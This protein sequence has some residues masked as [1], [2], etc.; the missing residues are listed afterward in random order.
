MI[1]RLLL[2][3]AAMRRLCQK[4]LSTIEHYRPSGVR[5][6]GAGGR[7][8]LDPQ[9]IPTLLTTSLSD[10]HCSLTLTVTARQAVQ[11][12]ALFASQHP[13]SME[14][15]ANG[16]GRRFFTALIHRMR[17]WSTKT[18]TD[19]VKACVQVVGLERCDSVIQLKV[20]LLEASHSP[21]TL[22]EV[23]WLIFHD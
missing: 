13:S 8:H 14:K 12:V 23:E 7:E 1:L 11:K 4:R 3:S 2:H 19:I 15:K 5:K 10:L 20:G 9:R 18:N 22:N 16:I 21:A 6:H 17:V